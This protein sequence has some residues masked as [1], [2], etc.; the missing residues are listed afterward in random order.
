MSS[1]GFRLGDL[2]SSQ[3]AGLAVVSGAASL[4][5]G[6]GTA[7]GRCRVNACRVKERVV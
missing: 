2:L 1:P 3:R 7:H 5:P 4:C 6:Q